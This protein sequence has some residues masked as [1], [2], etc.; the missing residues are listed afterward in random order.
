MENFNYMNWLK[1]RKKIGK[2][3]EMLPKEEE[4]VEEKKGIERGE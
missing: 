2:M 3:N 4:E 1:K